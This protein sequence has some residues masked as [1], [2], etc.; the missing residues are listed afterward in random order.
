MHFTSEAGLTEWESGSRLTIRGGRMRERYLSRVPFE[1]AYLALLTRYGVKRLSRWERHLSAEQSSILS[2]LGLDVVP[3]ERRTLL[4]RKV[5]EAV[6]SRKKQYTDF[7]KLRFGGTRVKSSPEEVRL[8]GFLFGYPACCVDAFIRHPYSRNDLTPRDQRILFH[9]TCPGC[10]VT[11]LLLREYHGIYR[12]CLKIFGGVQPFE[13]RTLWGRGTEQKSA[14][15]LALR[16]KALPAAAGLSALLLFPQAGLTLDPHM[17]PVGDDM[18]TDYISY[19]EE[20]VRGYLPRYA[21]INGDGILDGMNEA[22]LIE[23]LIANLPDSA[24]PDQPYRIDVG[25]DGVEYCNICGE[26]VDMGFTRIVNPMRGLEMDIPFICLH[27][28][29]HGS[30]GYDG[31]IHSGRLELALIKRILLSADPPHI[32]IQ[33]EGDTDEDGMLD[34]EE[35]FV[36]TDPLVAD[37]DLDSVDDGPQLFENLLEALGE[38]PRE[39]RDDGP[40]VV[41][42]YLKGVETCDICGAVLNMGWLEIVNPL[43]GISLD[44]E[45]VP[46]MALHYLAHGSAVFSGGYNQGRVLPVLLRTVLIGDGSSHWLEVEGDTDGDGL[47]DVEESRFCYDPAINDTNGDGV[48]DGVELTGSMHTMINS[49]PEGPLPDQTYIIHTPTYG[50]YSCLICGE[51][52]NMGFIQV[53]NPAEETSIDIPYYNLHFMAHGSFSTDRP[54]LYPRIDPRDID[55]VIHISSGTVQPHTGSAFLIYPNPFRQSA[56]ISFEL[57]VT[58]DVEIAITDVTGKLVF[59]SSLRGE[60]KGEFVWKGI[61]ADGE[62]LAAGVYFCKLK[63]GSVTLT[64]KAVILE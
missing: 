2:Q 5:G 3:V 22:A 27:Y 10:K 35:T 40:Y 18:D 1:L 51:E 21:D 20:T 39:P 16:R 48:P 42:H 24:Q 25:M 52:I 34:E 47:K 33:S 58:A 37:T 60:R 64:R 17:I 14:F 4:R 19:A 11:P 56:R 7:Y 6:F 63:V 26:P 44:M 8:E 30:L 29:E 15:A 43:E 55:D 50:F 31:T 36:G 54:D 45:E 41:E 23:S 9:W 49:L 61:D 46:F 57:P 13:E 62:R 12:E 59:E 53:V 32:M 38:L 28:L